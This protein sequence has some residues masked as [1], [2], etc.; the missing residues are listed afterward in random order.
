MKAASQINGKIMGNSIT[1]AGIVGSID[2]KYHE[3]ESLP[4][5]NALMCSNNKL[6]S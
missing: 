5:I 6:K 1:D 3:I 2:F 4:C